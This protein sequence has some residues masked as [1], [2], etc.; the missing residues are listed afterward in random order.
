MRVLD[1]ACGS[2]SFLLGAYE[3]LLRWYRDAYAQNPTRWTRG[4]SPRIRSGPEGEWFLTTTERKNILLR[5]IY[6]VDIDPQAVEVTK[7]SLLLKVLEG[8]SAEALESQLEL[9]QERALP[10]LARNIKCGNSLIEPDFYENEQIGLLDDDQRMRVNVFD[11]R[12]EYEEVFR[13]A[14]GFDEVIGN[15][16]YLDSETMTEFTPEWRRYCVGKYGSASGN[17]DVF[18]VFIERAL[19]LSRDG[20]RHSFI[21]PNKL[22]STNYS[23]NIRA[24]IASVSLERVRDYSSIPVFPVAVYPIVYAIATGAP[25]PS[26]PV[27][28]ERMVQVSNGAVAIDRAEDLDR[29]RYFPPDGSPWPIFAD[30]HESSPI[31]RMAGTYAPLQEIADVHG[32]ATVAE[33]YAM[34][35]L[36]TEA[37]D[38]GRVASDALR[39][40]NS[41]TIDRYVK[42]WGAKRMRYLGSSYLRP[43]VT[44]EHQPSLPPN[45]L[46]QA[47]RPKAIIA[48]M[49]RTL[50]V[51]ADAEGVILPGKSTTVVEPGDNVDLLWL[52]GIL[53]SRL[54]AFYYLS[55]FGGDRLQGGY[56]RI[57]PPQ[58]R[59]IPIPPYRDGPT[60]FELRDQV[61]VL[62]DAQRRRE[63]ART[64]SESSVFLREVEAADARIDALVYELYELTDLERQVVERSTEPLARA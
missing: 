5:H 46:A 47:Q 30:I 9:F 63:A 6:G 64:P 57:G 17:W 44:K 19:Q 15:P 49:T 21:V 38:E 29:T 53:N 34:A 59:T 4:R 55:V 18:C 32:A 22:G 50:E 23:T 33:A 31:D 52:L 20:G 27:R 1:P 13:T 42:Y 14:G 56:L 40:V 45:R 58:V 54:V 37:A 16:P 8:E 25:E 28:Y 51:I 60:D 41:G 7:L 3:F 12:R 35:P 43:V 39:V 10:D 62:L 61:G 36:I 24:I 11:W 48:G 26:S 2:G